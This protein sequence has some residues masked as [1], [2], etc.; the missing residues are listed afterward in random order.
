MR[1]A[2]WL[3]LGGSTA[4]VAALLVVVP[5]GWIAGAENALSAWRGWLG[6]ARVAAI[7]AAWIWWEPLVDRL[8]GVGPEAAAHLKRRRN[9]WTGALLAVELVVVRNVFGALWRLAA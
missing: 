3:V 4:C 6:G 2:N 1:S 9:F 5:S 8:P 7:A